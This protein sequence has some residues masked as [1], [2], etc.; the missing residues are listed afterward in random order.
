LTTT[1]SKKDK[2][3][4]TSGVAPSPASLPVKAGTDETKGAKMTDRFIER[5]AIGAMVYASVVLIG[6]IIVAIVRAL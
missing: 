6:H 1:A 5:L 3:V 2:E 4:E